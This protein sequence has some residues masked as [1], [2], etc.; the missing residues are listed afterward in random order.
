MSFPH[1]VRKPSAV[2]N[3]I[4]RGLEKVT[5]NIEKLLCPQNNLV[6]LE[7][8]DIARFSKKNFDPKQFFRLYPRSFSKL[9]ALARHFVVSTCCW[10]THAFFWLRRIFEN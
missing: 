6:S 1:I 2:E 4:S 10:R 3:A 8:H 7:N 5:K 9:R